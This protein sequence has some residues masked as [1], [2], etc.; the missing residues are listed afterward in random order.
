MPADLQ[1]DCEKVLAALQGAA[2]LTRTEI[3]AGVFRTHRRAEYLEELARHLERE[4]SIRR[5]CRPP[6]GGDFRRAAE[7]W[8]LINE[9][10]AAAAAAER[11]RP[12]GDGWLPKDETLRLARRGVMPAVA[13]RRGRSL[14]QQQ[15][16]RNRRVSDE[17]RGATYY[18][19]TAL[20][21]YRDQGIIEVEGN[22]IRLAKNPPRR[23]PKHWYEA[24]LLFLARGHPTLDGKWRPADDRAPADRPRHQPTPRPPGDGWMPRAE[25]VAQARKG[26]A[27]DVAAR[28]GREVRR[29]DAVRHG[30]QP[31]RA[32]VS[33]ETRG[34][35][36]FIRR[37]LQDY[38]QAGVVEVEGEWIRLAKNPSRRP[39]QQWHEALLHC[40]AQG[41]PHLDGRWEAEC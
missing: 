30:R 27:P 37:A 9:H 11:S 5:Y 8:E 3:Y 34:A 24:L 15:G 29:K 17:T 26:I 33:D 21:N 35:S 4:G 1:A 12:P 25:V 19:T 6:G 36:D 22:W 13:A 39:S 10:D 7:V 41:H 31:V 20:A 18:I 2:S 38:R 40:L 32:V 14:R 23:P 28:H 16:S